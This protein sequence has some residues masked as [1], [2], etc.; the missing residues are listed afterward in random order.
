MSINLA[1]VSFFTLAVVFIGANGGFYGS[2]G[3][4]GGPKKFGPIGAIIGNLSEEQRQELWSILRESCNET[5][6]T[7]KLQ[8][9]TFVGNLSSEL[10]AEVAEV[11][12]KIDDFKANLSQRAQNLSSAAQQL[13]SNITVGLKQQYPSSFIPSVDHEQ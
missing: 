6:G 10:Q 8:I 12:Q 1:I 4:S 9:N 11:Q 7:I 13:Y 2:Q 5:K 3:Y